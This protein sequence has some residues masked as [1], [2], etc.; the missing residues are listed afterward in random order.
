MIEGSRRTAKVTVFKVVRWQRKTPI[1]YIAMEYVKYLADILTTES[2]R[3]VHR[4]N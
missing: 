4:L 3:I 1:P 2:I